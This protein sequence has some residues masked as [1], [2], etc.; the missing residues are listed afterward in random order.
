MDDVRCTGNE[1]TLFECEFA[2]F[3]NHNCDHSEDA[4][5]RVR[6]RYT[7]VSICLCKVCK[8]SPFLT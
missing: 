6:R 4:G 1:A 3:G 5:V 2:G 7:Y 8:Q